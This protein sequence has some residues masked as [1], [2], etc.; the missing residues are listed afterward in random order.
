MLGL[1]EAGILI[2]ELFTLTQVLWGFPME[3]QMIGSWFFWCCL[4]TS[5]LLDWTQKSSMGDHSGSY[6]LLSSYQELRE[7][8][9]L[10]KTHIKMTN[11]WGF[12]GSPLVRTWH[13]HCRGLGSISDWVTK[14]LQAAAWPRKRLTQPK[15]LF[16]MCKGCPLHPH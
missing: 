3:R 13:F 10:A 11:P 12:P 6:N 7:W 14:I 8:R 1:K 4:L 9:G 16:L 15:S 5:H 2:Y